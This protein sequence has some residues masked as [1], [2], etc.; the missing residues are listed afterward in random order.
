M[1][2]QKHLHVT[3]GEE[4]Q[5]YIRIFVSLVCYSSVSSQIRLAAL[6]PNKEGQFSRSV[7]TIITVSVSVGSVVHMKTNFQPMSGQEPSKSAISKI[8][9]CLVTSSNDVKTMKN[10]FCVE[11]WEWEGKDWCVPKK[12]NER[13]IREWKEDSVTWLLLKGGGYR[14]KERAHA[15][16]VNIHAAATGDKRKKAPRQRI[17]VTEWEGKRQEKGKVT[18]QQ[19]ARTTTQWHLHTTPA[20]RISA[21]RSHGQK[22]LQV[23]FFTSATIK[24]MHQRWPR[25]HK[26][27]HPVAV[28]LQTV[29]LVREW[30]KSER[31]RSRERRRVAERLTLHDPSTLTTNKSNYRP[32]GIY[33]PRACACV[34]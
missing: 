22:Y 17:T 1:C 5:T 4:K 6:K 9:R 21:H 26:R 19:A 7:K 14:E 16:Q 28:R 8:F 18:R 27:T 13:R 2:D 33:S 32:S 12:K 10:T 29:S 30:Q 20:E 34:C 31:T 25:I 24:E 11:R 15:H 3:L 23:G